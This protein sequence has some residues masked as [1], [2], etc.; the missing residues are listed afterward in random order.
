MFIRQANTILGGSS[1]F[2]WTQFPHLYN[3]NDS[4]LAEMLRINEVNS[5]GP[6]RQI[7]R[8]ESPIHSIVHL[9]LGDGSSLRLA[10]RSPG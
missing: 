8:R 2:F 7:L 6:S 5:A 3:G 4:Q 10:K 9:G 1:D